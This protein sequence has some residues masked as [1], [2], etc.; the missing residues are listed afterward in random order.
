DLLKDS[1]LVDFSRITFHISP[2]PRSYLELEEMS[3]LGKQEIIT[4]AR[5]LEYKE[6]DE[7]NLLAIQLLIN[8]KAFC[9]L[10]ESASGANAQ[11]DILINVLEKIAEIT[12][13]S[14]ESKIINELNETRKWPKRVQLTHETQPFD[15]HNTKPI[16]PTNTQYL[17]ARKQLALLFKSNNIEPGRYELTTAKEIINVISDQY[18]NLIYEKIYNLDYDLLL[19]FSLANHDAYVSDNYIQHTR[20]K[21]S[22]QHEVTY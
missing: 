15:S 16:E 17:H 20:L 5:L 19:K 12:K 11:V 7:Q 13:S 2:D 22:L 18:K 14:I 1:F 8:L 10:V 21:L 4:S 6:N 3:P 9:Q